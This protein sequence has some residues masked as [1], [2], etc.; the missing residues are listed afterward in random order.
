MFLLAFEIGAVKGPGIPKIHGQFPDNTLVPL[1]NSD[2][3]LNR[4][5]RAFLHNINARYL[6][7]DGYVPV[8]V[9]IGPV[10]GTAIPKI[11]IPQKDTANSLIIH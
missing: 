8:S 6:S 10:K 5:G 2:S 1:G 4:T 9:E 11:E 7:R 3:A